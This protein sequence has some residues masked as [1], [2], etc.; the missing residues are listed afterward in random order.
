M[1]QNTREC[2]Y[3]LGMHRQ[4]IHCTGV[5]DGC[6][7]VQSFSR[8]GM[9]KDCYSRFC[10]GSYHR[11]PTAQ[12]LNGLYLRFQI[13]ACP[14]NSEVECLHP[15]QCHLCGWHPD[16]ARDRL[17]RFLQSCRIE[18]DGQHNASTEALTTHGQNTDRIQTKF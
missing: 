18:A 9:E 4:C 1:H 16:V 2:P 8:P 11:C 7:I 5:T 6:H 12:M 15:D 14:N 17:A 10:S 3:F 13:H